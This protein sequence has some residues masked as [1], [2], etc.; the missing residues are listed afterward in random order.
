MRLISQNELEDILTKRV[1]GQMCDARD[2]ELCDVNLRGF[3]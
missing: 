3:D 2:I 1:K